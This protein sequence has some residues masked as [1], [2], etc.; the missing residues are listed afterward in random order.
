MAAQ[1]TLD[2]S[3]QRETLWHMDC[4]GEYAAQSLVPFSIQL[5]LDKRVLLIY[6]TLLS[7]YS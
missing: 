4:K 6:P 5:S 7:R 3:E 2:G 1:V